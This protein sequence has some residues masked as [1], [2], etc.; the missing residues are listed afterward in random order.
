MSPQTV[1]EW[2]TAWVRGTPYAAD[3]VA[4]T[5][6]SATLSITY[7]FHDLFIT[8][9]TPGDIITQVLH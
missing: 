7:T 1:T 3:G 6:Q 4:I 2:R 5:F 9:L 8:L